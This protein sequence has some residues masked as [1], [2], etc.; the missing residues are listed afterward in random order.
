MIGIRRIRPSLNE[1]K[2]FFNE[3]TRKIRPELIINHIEMNYKQNGSLFFIQMSPL[4]AIFGSLSSH[5]GSIHQIAIIRGND[6]SSR[7]KFEFLVAITLMLEAL[8]PNLSLQKKSRLLESVYFFKE[9]HDVFNANV[10]ANF[11]DIQVMLLSSL[12]GGFFSFCVSF[13]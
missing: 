8:K 3:K 7:S 4:D 1:F 9:N 11:E 12:E 13:R 5:D 6:G 10:T 2:V